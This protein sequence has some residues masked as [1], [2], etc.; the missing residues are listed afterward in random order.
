MGIRPIYGFGENIKNGE[1]K[2]NYCLN[3]YVSTS[4]NDKWSGKIAEPNEDRSDGPFATIAGARDAVR[5]YKLSGKLSGSAAVWIRGGR[6][7]VT[8]PIIFNTEDSAPVTYSAYPGEHPVMEGGKR[9]E[10]W[11]VEELGHIKAWVADLPE[12][13]EGKWYFHQLFVNGE[14]RQRPR[15]PKKGYFWMED[16]PGLNLDTAGFFESTDIFKCA[17]GD[18]MNWKNLT[19]IDI[20]VF[21]YWCEERMPVM[22]YDENTHLVKCSRRSVFSLKDDLASRYSKFYAENVFEAMSEPGEW[23]LDGASG[24]LYYIPVPG[25]DI[26]NTEVFAPVTE[27]ILKISG[28]PENGQYVEFLKFEGLEFR[29]AEW[30]L[31]TEGTLKSIDNLVEYSKT[32]C[33]EISFNI[34]NYSVPVKDLATT[35]Q[36]AFYIPGVICLE[37]A[38]YC[39]IEDCTVSHA[40]LYGIELSD[41]CMANRIVGNRIYDMGAGGIK[42]GGSDARGLAARR[43]GNNVVTDNHIYAVG[44]VFFSAAGILSIHS[45]G[46]TISHNHIHDLFYSG[47]SCGW[48]WGYEENISKNNH[49]EKNHIHDLGH[50]MLSDMGGIYILGV[51]PGTIIRGNIIHDIEK[52][53][54]GGWAIYTDEGSSH[55]LIENNICYNTSSQSYHHHCGRENIIRNNVFAFGREGQ[56]IHNR[57]ESFNAFTFEK[58]I[59]ITDGQPVFVG[60]YAGQLEKCNFFSDLNLFWDISGKQLTNGN[61]SYNENAVWS[62]SCSFS[63]D[64]WRKMGY[65]LQSIVADPI[66]RDLTMYDFSIADNSPA[67]A[68][69]FKQIDT[70]D[71]GPRSN[72]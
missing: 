60:G 33:H 16:V 22:S 10:G 63:M 65:D 54:Y 40:G 44:R 61:G 30:Q 64:E 59:V 42:L 13:A 34:E 28:N 45:F 52:S 11:K 14:R 18:I 15:L 57:A 51:Q 68:L 32:E 24:K 4:G 53:N 8:E 47:I 38:R 3:L 37:G 1:I 17:P 12:V 46:N 56:I 48:V 62:L 66:C 25:E 55:I 23:Y 29:Y 71:A 41:G 67:L 36:A 50:G 6:Y 58:N 20:M 69:G 31:P 2:M 39:A 35:P 7:A 9:I 26:D 70:S 5:K 21:H 49:I 72:T 27:Q 43:T 19:D